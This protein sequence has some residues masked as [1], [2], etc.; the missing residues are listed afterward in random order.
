MAPCRL[1]S[2]LTSSSVGEGVT[3]TATQAPVRATFGG[4]LASGEFRA[5]WLAH[6]LSRSGD[7]LATFALA[8]VVYQRTG[9]GF[10]VAVTVTFGFVPYAIGGP[11]LSGL[12]D[13]LPR[14]TLMVTCD[15]ARAV[16]VGAMIVPGLPL[17]VL[18]ALLCTLITL[19]SPFTAARAA[20]VPDILPG[21]PYVLGN[22]VMNVTT[23]VSRFAGAA[24]GGVLVAVFGA[25]TALTVDAATFL[26]SAVLIR[27]GLRWRPVPEGIA[28]TTSP[29]SG[30]RA[31]T[32]LVVDDPV[33]LR[34]ALLGLLGAFYAVPRALAVPFV[35]ENSGGTADIGLLLAADPAGTIVG[36]LVVGRLFGARARWALMGPLAVL[37]CAPLILSGVPLGIW[38]AFACWAVAGVGTAYNL[39]ANAAFVAAVPT[40]LRG[41]AFGLVTTCMAVSQGVVVLAAGALTSVLS[42]GQ[43]IAAFAVVGT[44]CAGVLARSLRTSGVTAAPLTP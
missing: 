37:S 15:L 28:Y 14:R 19:E 2:V 35:D 23:E 38:V 9:S 5:L 4:L 21:E 3:A 20:T 42:A 41:Q 11:L 34:L 6:L 1:H 27:Y 26:L 13:R 33:L 40:A 7:E 12:A 17:V 8:L 10:L 18:W 30:L 44:L 22:A 25:S 43:V 16:L 36:A 29:L 31:A 39:P 32:R 24:A